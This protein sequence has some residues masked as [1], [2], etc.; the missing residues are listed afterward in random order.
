M[1]RATVGMAAPKSA[2]IYVAL[3]TDIQPSTGSRI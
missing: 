1:R 2:A 3:Y